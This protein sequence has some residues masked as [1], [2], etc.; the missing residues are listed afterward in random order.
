MAEKVAGIAE[1]TQPRKTQK[2]EAGEGTAVPRSPRQTQTRQLPPDPGMALE[3]ASPSTHLGL[4]REELNWALVAHA[5]IV[6]TLLLGLLTGG[7]GAILGVII[8]ALIWYMHRGKSEYVVDQARQATVFQLAG[9]VALLLLVVVGA[10]LVVVGW[11]VSAILVI[12][13]IGLIL[14]P[15]MLALT[16]A[17]VVAIVALPIAQVVY[18]CYAALEAYS[19]RPFRY[20]WTADLVDRYQVQAA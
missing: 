1:E 12:V 5:S 16:L 6:V 17:W 4:S 18:G 2:L 8:P 7:L 19:G 14:L 11:T 20:R 13:L 9:F 15:L 3:V 10:L